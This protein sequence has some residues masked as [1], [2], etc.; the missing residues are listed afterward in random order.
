MP[1]TPNMSRTKFQL[2]LA[3]FGTVDVYGFGIPRIHHNSLRFDCGSLLASEV[4]TPARPTSTTVFLEDKI[5]E[6]IDGELVRQGHLNEWETE[7]ARKNQKYTAPM[8]DNP[9]ATASLMA[10]DFG[11]NNLNPMELRRDKALADRDPQQ[12]CADRCVATG[13]CDVYEDM[14]SLSPIE[15]VQFCKECVLP[16]DDEHECAIPEAMYS[17]IIDSAGTNDKLAP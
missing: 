17:D 6:M 1:R 12:Y 9:D 10:G 8:G 11:A 7:W 3:L 14:F 4:R 2:L 15:V 13:N 16:E 5:A